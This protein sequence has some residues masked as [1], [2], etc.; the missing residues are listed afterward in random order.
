M[1]ALTGSLRSKLAARD[2]K[3][4]LIV[5]EPGTGLSSDGTGAW[6][7]AEALAEDILRDLSSLPGYDR[8]F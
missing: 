5:H 4:M 8:P 2:V 3:V 6:R 7:D 1:V